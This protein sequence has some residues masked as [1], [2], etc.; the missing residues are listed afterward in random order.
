MLKTFRCLIFF[1]LVALACLAGAGEQRLLVNGI[2][3]S[4]VDEGSGDPVV[5][6]HGSMSDLRFWEPQR[7]SFSRHFRFIAYTLRY[8]G[9]SGWPDEGKNYS[10][11]THAAD[12]AAFIRALNL[13]QVHLV[14][15]SYGGLIAAT[16]ALDHPEL[17]RSLTLAEPLLTALLSE[18]PDTK[19]VIEDR[20]R[21]LA[22]AVEALKAGDLE[23]ATKLFFEWVNNQGEGAFERLP[24]ASRRMML[25][26]ARTVPLLMAAPA[27]SPISCSALSGLNVPTLV[28]RGEK[29]PRFFA[30]ISETVVRCVP[31]SQLITIADATH[32]MSFQQPVAFN[33]ALMQFLRQH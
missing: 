6:V 2:E 14:A 21:G 26:N 30:L 1:A 29:T 27:P 22:P 15:L 17:L 3:L 8:H 9:T 5:F 24:D 32:P 31:G 19:P 13:G 28:V 23:R 4:Y 20:G 7:T 25:D 10:A 16:M 11:A 12:L 18:T 33:D